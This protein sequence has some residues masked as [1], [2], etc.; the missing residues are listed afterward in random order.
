MIGSDNILETDILIS[1]YDEQLSSTLRAGNRNTIG[2]FGGNDM[3][4]PIGSFDDSL[5]LNGKELGWFVCTKLPHMPQW[6]QSC[7]LLYVST[8]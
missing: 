8:P 4:S 7:S 6:E 5:L 2:F 3:G 1:T